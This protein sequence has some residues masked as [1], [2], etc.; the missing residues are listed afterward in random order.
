VTEPWWTHQICRLHL[1]PLSPFCQPVDKGGEVRK[2]EMYFA[3]DLLTFVSC[4][5]RNFIL[6][7]FE[8]WSVIIVGAICACLYWQV[9][10]VGHGHNLWMLKNFKLLVGVIGLAIGW[11][12]VKFYLVPIYC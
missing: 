3:V 4:E 6:I 2:I 11:I 1:F 5:G 12:A 8:V 9:A 7:S 10:G